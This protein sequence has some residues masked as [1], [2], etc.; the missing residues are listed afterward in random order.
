MET[1]MPPGPALETLATRQA[2]SL[3][4]ARRTGFAS[5]LQQGRSHLRPGLAAISTEVHSGRVKA[6]LTRWLRDAH[7]LQSGCT[8][9]DGGRLEPFGAGPV[10]L[11]ITFNS[12]SALA[13]AALHA[14]ALNA[15]LRRAHAAGHAPNVRARPLPLANKTPPLAAC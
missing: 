1:C 4:S 8:D 5:S 2:G 9:T 10:Q 11:D 15:A 7:A 13:A 6:R 3:W 14:G 12:S